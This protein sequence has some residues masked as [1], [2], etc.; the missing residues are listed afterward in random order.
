MVNV[1]ETSALTELLIRRDLTEEA[2]QLTK[3][4]LERNTHPLPKI[5]RF[6]LNKLAVNGSV[7]EMLEI[8]QYLNTKVK[9]DVSFDNRLCNAY[10]SAGRGEEFLDLMVADLDAAVKAGNRS[11]MTTVQDRFPRGGA[12]GLLDTHPH[13]LDRFDKLATKFADLGYIAPMN[14]LW[15]YHFIHQDREKADRIWQDYVKDS[16]QIMFQKVCQVARATGNLELA[17][18]LVNQLSS[19]QHVSGGAKGIAYSC[20]LDCLCAAGKHQEGWKALQEAMEGGVVLQDVNRTALV[21]LKQGLE[22][23]GDDFP[24]EIPPKNPCRDLD[25]MTSSSPA[26][27]WNDY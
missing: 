3:T 22:D 1:T 13:L 10:L 4:M 21:R 8:G 11:L 27:D 14:V 16:N 25:R 20:L 2:T 12:M 24:Y 26:I 6:L 17:F 9:K 7:E 19:A 18:G 23:N 5:F 15:T